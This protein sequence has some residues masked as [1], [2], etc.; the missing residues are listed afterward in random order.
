MLKPV[1]DASSLTPHVGVREVNERSTLAAF[2]TEESR[3]LAVDPRYATEPPSRDA[4]SPLRVGR[5]PTTLLAVGILRL[6]HVDIT[7]PDLELATAYYVE[8]MGLEVSD[9]TEDRMF[10]KCWDERDHHCLSIREDTRVGLDRFSFKVDRDDDL[11]RFESRLERAGLPV[12]RVADGDEIG[13]GESIRFDLPS[14]HEMEL[15]HDV[16][17]V[18]GRLPLLNPP[19]IVPNLVGIAPPRIDHLLVHA[20]E[21]PEVARLFQSVLGFRLTEQLLDGGGHQ[22]IAFLERSARPHDI[23]FV[24]GP[25]GALH[26]VS[27]WLD[28]WDHVRRAADLLAYHGV[29]IDVGPTR[30]GLTRGNTIYF[31]DPMGTRNE[32]FTGGYRCDPDFPTITWTDDRA[33]RAVFYYEGV[34]NHRF[35]TVNT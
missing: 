11:D 34:L 7:A 13:Q 2:D 18:G 24:Q 8:V 28:D 26:H 6:S 21:V 30:H 10:F 14:G 23:A 5:H 3:F 19:P 33:G 9:R 4:G 29:T 32:V 16:H 35:A 15:V 17:K 12:R 27:F 1:A 20:E 22:T 25:N 31:F